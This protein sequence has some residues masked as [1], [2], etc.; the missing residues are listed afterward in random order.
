[1]SQVPVSRSRG[2]RWLLLSIVTVLAVG[3]GL[4]GDTGGQRRRPAGPA[5]LPSGPP[6]AVDFGSG[7]G[8][9]PSPSASEPG[10]ALSAPVALRIPAIGVDTVLTELGLQPDGT[11]EVPTIYAQ[12]GWYGLG[13]SPGE[14]GS[15][16][17]LGHVDSHDGPA[18]FYKLR[19]LRPGDTVEVNMADGMLTRFVVTAVATYPKTRF[20]A[21]SV[22][23]PRGYSALQ[24]V[25]CGG[26]FDPR[27]RSYQ[28]NV[29][30]YTSL[31][32]VVP[33]VPG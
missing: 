3:A 15:A 24:L 1:M 28:S 4:V 6:P 17:I 29:V 12:A 10:L 5:D 13:P 33:A 22:Y 23:G 16:V 7:T 32:E 9:G 2:R 14:A 30:V 21:E 8:P 11:V 18:V 27:S 26:T 19:R 31:V 25:T 20:P